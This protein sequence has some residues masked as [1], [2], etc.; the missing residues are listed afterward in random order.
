MGN[1]KIVFF[2]ATLLSVVLHLLLYFV[3]PAIPRAT[4]GK[5][6]IV[7]ISSLNPLTIDVWCEL[8]SGNSSS[9][10]PTNW[11]QQ[12]HCPAANSSKTAS[13]FLNVNRQNG[14][15]IQSCRQSSPTDIQTDLCQ[16]EVFSNLP[17]GLRL[18]QVYKLM[19]NECKVLHGRY[20]GS[21]DVRCQY[22]CAVATGS[23]WTCPSDATS[24]EGGD[25]ITTL[26]SYVAL[27][28]SATVGFALCIN[29][30]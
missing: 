20:P 25:R 9:D 2:I 14:T 24:A 15:F 12:Q 23:N 3:V 17:V 16:T 26:A 18:D 8:S 21:G 29:C 10:F 28:L 30:L 4:D 1:Y 22:Q 27:R 13:S 5:S 19:E 7:N 11:Q 6:T